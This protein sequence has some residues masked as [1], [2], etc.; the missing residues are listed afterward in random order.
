M[1]K[2]YRGNIANE[3]NM[4]GCITF[5]TRYIL[6]ILF[7]RGGLQNVA[8]GSTKAVG[9][10]WLTVTSLLMVSSKLVIYSYQ[11]ASMVIP[12]RVGNYEL[13]CK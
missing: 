2:N 9:S 7:C 5:A 12:C 10:T 8:Y 1:Y 6:N 3:V 13:K 4:L 11:V